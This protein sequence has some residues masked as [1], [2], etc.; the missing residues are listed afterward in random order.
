MLKEIYDLA[1]HLATAES[2][3]TLFG[4]YQN[5]YACGQLMVTEPKRLACEAF[6]S[7]PNCRRACA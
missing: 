1:P 7:I 3:N 6:C 5:F 4:G 2:A